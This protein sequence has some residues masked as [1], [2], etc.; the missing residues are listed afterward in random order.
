MAYFDI[1]ERQVVTRVRRGREWSRAC[2]TAV[3]LC[4]RRL[5]LSTINGT[6]WSPIQ[7]R[8]P[9]TDRQNI[10]TGNYVDDHYTYT[11][12]GAFDGNGWNITIFSFLYLY[13]FSVTHLWVSSVERLMAQATPNHARMCLWGHI[14][15]APTN[16]VKSQDRHFVAWIDI[17]K[18]HR[19][20]IKL[21]II[22]KR[23]TGFIRNSV[24]KYGRQTVCDSVCEFLHTL[25]HAK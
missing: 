25:S 13:L 18:P 17:F 5:S 15:F 19:R 16:L 21:T 24:R 2:S 20:Q 11:E 14:D 10:V 3:A 7:N 1:W 22:S 12:F 8:Q 6:I 4:Q 23:Q 9:L